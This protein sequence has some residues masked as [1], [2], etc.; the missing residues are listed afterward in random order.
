M[1]HLVRRF[2][3]LLGALALFPFFSLRAELGLPREP[4]G[5]WDRKGLHS[6]VSYP[7]AC[8]QSVDMS[9]GKVQEGGKDS[10]NWPDI[11]ANLASAE[12]QNQLITCKISPIDSSA[13]DDVMRG[14]VIKNLFIGGKKVTTIDGFARTRAEGRNLEVKIE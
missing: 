10:C 3:L 2:F 6:F 4:F 13:L 5:V 11:D 9:W 1:L 7:C 8:G 12:A 14:I